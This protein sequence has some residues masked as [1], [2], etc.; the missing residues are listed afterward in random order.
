[1]ELSKVFKY[2]D[3]KPRRGGRNTA[4]GE[5]NAEGVN[6]THGKAG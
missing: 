3:F 5:A 6:V 1:M 2:A 4:V